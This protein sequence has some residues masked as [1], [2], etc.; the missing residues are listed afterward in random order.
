LDNHIH[1]EKLFLLGCGYDGRAGKAYLKLL[2]PETQ[3]VKLVYD[4]TGHKPYCYVKEVI[5]KVREL[6][7]PGVVELRREKKYDLLRDQEVEVTKIIASDPLAIGGSSN[8]IREK[9]RAWE[10][11]IPYHLCYLYDMKLTPSMPYTLADGEPIEASPERGEVRKIV[12]KIFGDFSDEEKEL[13]VDWISLLEADQPKFKHLSLDIEVLSPVATRIPSP[14]KARDKVG[15]VALV[16]SDG[17]REVYLLK[18][19]RL[20]DVSGTDSLEVKVYEDE[21]KMLKELF[22]VIREYPVI[23][24][25][26]GDDFDLPYLRHRAEALK[27]SKESVPITLGR[28]GASLRHGIHI[29]LYKFFM[30]K[31]IQVYAFDNKYREHTLE[32]IAQAI[33]G[34]GKIA[35][36]KP[37]GELSGEE[38][39]RYCFQDALLVHE[40]LTMDDEL[41]LKLL[42]VLSRISRMPIEDV[43]RHGVSG[44]IKS[45]LYFEHRR[46]GYL[47]P[48]HDELLEEKGV[49]STRAVIEGKKYRGAI[50]VEPAPG[51]HFNVTVLDFSSLYPSVL[52]EWNLSYETARCPHPE[53]RDNIVP[54]TSH[55]ICRKRRGIQSE[56]IGCLRD[57]RVKWYKPKSSDRSLSESLRRWYGV[58]QRALKVFLNAAYGVFGFEEFPLYCPPVAEST[59]AIARYAFRKTVEKAEELG[60]QVL[61]G[62][63]DS[64]FIKTGDE[65]VVERL[66]SWAK[67]ELKLDLELDKKYRYVVF[68]QRKKNYLGVTDKGVVDVKGLTGKK[69]HI[70]K[71]IKDAFD[72]MLRILQEVESEEEFSKAKSRIEELIKS[73]YQA[74]RR[75]EYDLEDLSFRVMLSK[76]VE[77]YIKTT[78]P[79]VK[80]AKKLMNRGVTV[81]PGDIITY[82]K[83]RDSNGV[84][85]LEF[86][87]KDQVDVDKYIEYL[88]STFEQ[89]LD[90]LGIDFNRITGVTNLEHF[91]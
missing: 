37:I 15:A 11:D 26:N 34:K 85:P 8:S 12:E 4:E 47:I 30:N 14:S 89:V 24:T 54:E 59:A 72:E 71:F 65:K 82:V 17:R 68:S 20:G 67:R 16:G 66:V 51:V 25:F 69:A 52:K 28:E 45:L 62:D 84:E 80:A 63:T 75:G 32:A 22:E 49:I 9:I 53:C 1:E 55:W 60:V 61:Y 43:C 29:D 7:L 88:T 5:E 91:M 70:P 23:A 73:K 41:I 78:P 13:L 74:L 19:P 3:E 57:I 87:R 2:K 10:A 38:L 56:V 48:R 58:V 79:H 18:T 36:E 81:V 77:R 35:L 6:K 86:A 21:V 76:R 42:V 44:W 90:A 83:T 46:R 27:I 31:S 64:L 33:L 39:A 40:L 50:V